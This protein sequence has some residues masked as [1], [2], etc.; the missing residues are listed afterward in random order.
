M[1]RLFSLLQFAFLLLIQNIVAETLPEIPA[2]DLNVDSVEEINIEIERFSPLAEKDPQ[3][4][5]ALKY[6]RQA[7]SFVEK[8]A[9]YQSNEKGYKQSIE[10][11]PIKEKETKKQ[12]ESLSIKQSELFKKFDLE[13]STIE[14]NRLF[15]QQKALIAELRQQQ[16]V[17]LEK[18]SAAKLQPDAIA[19]SRDE[20]YQRLDIIRATLKETS[21]K[22]DSQDIIQA[23]HLALNMEQLSLQAQ[24]NMLEAHRL[25]LPAYLNL[26]ESEISLVK[27]TIKLEEEIEQRMLVKLE[28][29]RQ[30][31]EVK[32]RDEAERL[33]KKIISEFPSLKAVLDNNL[34]LNNQLNLLNQQF[35]ES[36]RK[37]LK[38][39]RRLELLEKNLQRLNQQLAIDAPDSLMGE[40]LY[41]QRENLSLIIGNLR[42]KK[43]ARLRSLQLGKARLN[44]FKVDDQ[45]QSLS[46]KEDFL[47]RLLTPLKEN[48]Q[49][50]QLSSQQKQ[51]VENELHT[52]LQNQSSLLKR[53][54]EQYINFIKLV[55]DL[56]HAEQ[57][58]EEKSRLYSE[59]LDEHLWLLP[60]NKLI[61]K[62]WFGDIQEQLIWL[63]SP[64]TWK[65]AIEDSI[66]SANQRVLKTFF[67]LFVV[68]M[69][70]LFKKRLK[71]QL[72][73]ISSRVNKVRKDSYWLTSQAL[74]LTALLA[75][76]WAFL[77]YIDGYLLS[78]A[79]QSE[80]SVMVGTVLIQLAIYIWLLEFIRLVLTEKGLAEVH[81]RWR[82]GLRIVIRNNLIWFVPA[83][84]LS[85]FF[86]A[87]T[88]LYFDQKLL[89]LTELG[90]LHFLLFLL[91]L[92]LFLFR[93]Y[94]VWNSDICTVKY[95][96]TGIAV[97]YL[98]VGLIAALMVAT[99]VG[100][101]LSAIRILVL[102]ITAFF[103]I[104]LLFVGYSLAMRWLRLTHIRLAYKQALER[105][106]AEL[107]LKAKML[108]QDATKSEI[109][110]GLQDNLNLDEID[111][112][113]VNT[114]VRRIL[115]GLLIVA[116]LIA[117]GWHFREVSPVLNTLD[118][119]SLWQY[120]IN[121][122]KMGITSLWDLLISVA[123][124]LLTIAG[125][126]NLPGLLEISILN[127]LGIEAG[128]R[129]A[130]A[131]IVQYI[132]FV[133]GFV[134]SLAW[135]GLAWTDVQWLV[136]AMSV[137]LGFGL[138]EIFSNFFSGLILLFERPIRIGDVVTIG[139][140]SGRVSKI[141]IRATTV[142]DWDRKELVIPNQS[143]ILENLINWTLSNHTTRISFMLGVAYG[144][145]PEFV[146][147]LILDTISKHPLVMEEPAPSALFLNFGDSS[148]DFRINVY[149]ADTD[150]RMKTKH[151]L[152][153][154]LEKVM[155]ENN[156]EIPFPQR[157]IN[158]R[159]A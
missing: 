46:E 153:M 70:F 111:L 120:K 75:S 11:N 30:Q 130:I 82:T 141:R 40:F 2:S 137:G 29:L 89:N 66:N 34:Q 27:Q 12:K 148:L 4:A 118:D 155:R 98:L 74:L 112:Q 126:R 49:W 138:K 147:K 20:V 5:V 84:A 80:F 35:T 63:Y 32:I 45:L 99:I 85:W 103:I 124:I 26:L 132:I 48:S 43:D 143:L 55:S 81:F 64:Q 131:R 31:S 87:T 133:V 56:E 157:D 57:Q 18:I 121:D 93:I 22:E 25:S 144:S 151:E 60:S 37:Y 33:S 134:V 44:Q 145:D 16:S 139:D 52:L 149:V 86:V 101:Y 73:S 94:Q 41:Q 109:Q 15:T 156:I 61:S 14:L 67:A 76:P 7:K 96:R 91:V 154:A 106:Q 28:L 113:L 102:L 19:K 152:H 95:K 39:N 129:Y 97:Y 119:I 115:K 72:L 58:V 78:K 136:T 65:Q 3:A 1:L 127:P 158:I 92:L 69:L 122:E 47:N 117:M 23:M 79:E 104:F 105:R 90:R 71:N 150:N 140:V 42:D 59:L 100:Y 53:L 135:L 62:Q 6:Y 114:Q 123:V 77:V 8:T 88:H 17:L 21:T 142:I 13:R 108:A 128:N 51:R 159:N 68:I 107:E 38:E 24:L 125:S 10:S 110:E 36:D 54:R 50:Q 116:I 83:F 9:I 146:Q